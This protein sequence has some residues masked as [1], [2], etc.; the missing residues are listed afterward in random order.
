MRWHC[1]PDTEFEIRALAVWG[2]ARYLSATEAPHN[3]EF[4]VSLKLEG[5]SGVRAR[6]LRLSKQAGLTTAPAPPPPP[7]CKVGIAAPTVNHLSPHDALKHYFASLKND[8]TFY[9]LWG[10][11]RKCS[12]NCLIITILFFHLPPTSSHFHSI[13]DEDCDRN[14]RLVVNEDDNGKFRLQR[15]KD[16]KILK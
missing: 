2:R 16:V 10:L 9:N 7:H 4:F 1:P 14:S 5:Q 6:D 11:E 12:W 3:S 8:L 15:V 13:Q